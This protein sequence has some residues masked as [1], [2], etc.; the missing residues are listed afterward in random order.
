MSE[1]AM[2]QAERLSANG[3]RSEKMREKTRLEM[4]ALL[5]FV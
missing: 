4:A 3:R 5:Y 2:K 1:W